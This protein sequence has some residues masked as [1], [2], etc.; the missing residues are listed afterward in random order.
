[1]PPS[2]AT[3]IESTFDAAKAAPGY[4]VSADGKTARLESGAPYHTVQGTS[5]I[6][7][8]ANAPNRFY[9]EAVFSGLVGGIGF[10]HLNDRSVANLY[11]QNSFLLSG[12]GDLYCFGSSIKG[13]SPNIARSTG[14]RVGVLLDMDVGTLTYWVDGQRLAHVVQHACL[15]TGEWYI[16]VTFGSGAAGAQFVLESPPAPS[17]PPS[18]RGPDVAAGVAANLRVAVVGA[19]LGGLSVASVLHRAGA[20]VSVF[21]L[22]PSGFHLR[23][24]AL[25]SVDVDLVAEIAG[26]DRRGRLSAIRGHGH[27]YGD[28]WQFLYEAL[29]DGTVR[30][31]VDVRRVLEPTSVAPR[32]LLG[33]ETEGEGVATEGFDLI[34]GADGGK[35]TLRSYVSDVLPSY[36]GYQVWRGLVARDRAPGP[37]SGRAQVNGVTYETLGFPCNGPPELGVLWNTGIYVATPEAEVQP[38]TRNRQVGGSAVGGG[39]DRGVPE[40][41]VPLV[42]TLFGEGNAAYWAA[43]ADHGKVSAH[44]VWELAADRVVHGRL[45]LLGD[46]A[47]MASPRT[48]AGAYTAM[49]DAVVLG[50]ALAAATSLDEALAIYDADTVRRGREL[51]QASRRAAGSFA[52]AGRP[53]LSP[54]EI[55]ARG[56][57]S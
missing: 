44:P 28:L 32:L 49:V 43:C 10:A 46:A 9:Y 37:P 57:T 55:A 17:P 29:P 53:I 24:G 35:S 18:P 31:G 8:S 33:G 38:P 39:S 16:T 56:A 11:N 7:K 51:Y 42:R 21:E 5:A 12:Y 47:H 52:P 40:W 26:G 4:S 36:A 2:S 14:S 34:V 45:A 1:M 41:F 13:V 3:W 22:Y 27:F 6:T 25:G 30:F 15:T 54:S 23:G 48:G 50:R 19:S 20:H